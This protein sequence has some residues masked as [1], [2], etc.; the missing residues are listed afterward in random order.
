[1]WNYVGEFIRNAAIRKYEYGKPNDIYE[2]SKHFLNSP[3]HDHDWKIPRAP[4]RPEDVN[5]HEKLR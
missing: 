2:P 4:C 1:M 5:T 3:E